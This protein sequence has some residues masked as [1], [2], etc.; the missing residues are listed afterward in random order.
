DRL[1]RGCRISTARTSHETT[2][3]AQSVALA[4]GW[5]PI[6]DQPAR[7]PP[8]FVAKN[9]KTAASP[10]SPTNVSGGSQNRGT[11]VTG[12]ADSRHDGSPARVLRGRLGERR[13]ARGVAEVA[14]RRRG[15]F[16]RQT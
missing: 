2:P 1:R 5:R 6:A 15:K 12:L 3:S 16:D 7:P 8:A 11:A 9:R 4:A 13:A 14:E 10:M